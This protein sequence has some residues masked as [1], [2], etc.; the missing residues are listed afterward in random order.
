[1]LATTTFCPTATLLAPQTIPKGW[2][3]PIFT[4]VKFNLSAPGCLTT[5]KTSPTT[6][7][8]RPPLKFSYFSND[9]TS[10]PIEVKIMDNFSGLTSC[11]KYSLSQR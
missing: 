8:A 11:G 10:S 4:L 3:L 7:P 2:S 6:K 9:S 1:M 5:S